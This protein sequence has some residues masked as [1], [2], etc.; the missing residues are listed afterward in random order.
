MKTIVRDEIREFDG[1][2]RFLHHQLEMGEIYCRIEVLQVNDWVDLDLE[3]FSFEAAKDQLNDLKKENP[4][5]EYRLR[6]EI[7]YYPV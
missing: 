7:N 3:P 5:N 4:T 2:D 6:L 1:W